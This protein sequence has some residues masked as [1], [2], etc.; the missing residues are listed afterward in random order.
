MVE[1]AAGALCGA[2]VS[3]NMDCIAALLR[4]HYSSAKILVTETSYRSNDDIMTELVQRGHDHCIEPMWEEFMK[5]QSEYRNSSEKQYQST[6]KD[7]LLLI[8]F[9]KSPKCMDALIKVGA[10]GNIKIEGEGQ[11][12]RRIPLICAAAA[13]EDDHIGLLRIAALAK[14]GADL[15][16]TQ[17]GCTP[18]MIA[19]KAKRYKLAEMLL[20]LGANPNI[21]CHA[22][23]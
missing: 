13:T 1:A 17:D 22:P 12:E 7:Q 6:L 16:D 10:A 9:E 21:I 23:P 14:G 8:A 19:L 5:T 4:N 11:N 2:I 3:G 15:D 20:N 18:L